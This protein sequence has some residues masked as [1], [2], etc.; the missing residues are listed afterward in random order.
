MRLSA[1]LLLLVSCLNCAVGCLKHPPVFSRAHIVDDDR[2]YAVGVVFHDR[3]GNRQ[4]DLGEPGVAGVGVSNGLDV[5]VTD[6]RGHYALSINDDTIIFVIKPSGWMTPVGRQ[7]NPEF[8]YVHKPAGSPKLRF[9]G[10]SPTGPLPASIDFPLY[11]QKES[12]RFRAVLFGDPQTYTKEEVFFFAHDIVEELVGFDA[13]FGVSLGDLVGDDLDLFH[14]LNEVISHVGVPWY[15]VLGNHDINFDAPNDDLSD[16]TYERVF[17]PPCYSFNYGKVHFIVL[18]NVYWTGEGSYE[19]KTKFHGQIGSRQLAFIDNDLKLVP[20]D[21]LI[22]LMMHIPL[23]EV[24]DRAQLFEILADRP[25]TLSMAAHFHTQ[26]HHFLDND[27]DW[28]GPGSHH[29]F[30]NATTSG[31]WWT[32]ELDEENIPHTTMSDGAPNGYSIITFEGAKYSIRFKAA[33]RPADHQISIY[34]PDEITV[35]EAPATEVLVNV[36]SGSTRSIVEM[37]LGTH[38]PWVPM[39]RVEREDAYFADLKKREAKRVHV[40][41]KLPEITK[42]EHLWVALLPAGP[43]IGSHLI[44]IRT[45]DMFG[46]FFE[47]NRI[48]SIHGE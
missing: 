45:T 38:G 8:C 6:K 7:N 12:R 39:V 9:A 48:I 28:C 3:N 36:F 19:D 22:V 17:G 23:T 10:V 46:Q 43:P 26:S 18:D 31:S 20:K 30:I 27:D 14:L 33:R 15:N 25:H 29:H 16:E 4:R 34:A 40:D 21:R 2:S 35:A 32:G 42:S 41:R 47:D 1:L 44:R 24:K 37:R 13:A 5:A 11:R